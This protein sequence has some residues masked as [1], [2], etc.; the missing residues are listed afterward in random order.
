M[1]IQNS[2]RNKGHANLRPWK[3][4][5]SGNPGGRPKGLSEAIRKRSGG[6]TG[7]KLIELYEAIAYA[8]ADWLAAHDYEVPTN[9][10][11]MKAAEWLSDHGYGKAPQSIE[12]G[13]PGGGPLLSRI[14]RVIVD[15]QT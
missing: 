11:R 15:P 10:E 13:G 6:D 7:P 2:G 14:E 9:L 4:G 12:I 5:Q 3:K 1:T 8:N